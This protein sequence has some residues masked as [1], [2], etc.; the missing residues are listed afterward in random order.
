MYKLC[1]SYGA[2]VNKT[3]DTRLNLICILDQKV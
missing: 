3:I 2:Q 1:T